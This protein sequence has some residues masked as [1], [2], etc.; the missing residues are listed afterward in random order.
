VDRRRAPTALILI[1]VLVGGCIGQANT[2]TPQP[3]QGLTPGATPGVAACRALIAADIDAAMRVRT[4]LGIDGIPAT[5]AAV[6]A[7]A[8]D[9]GSDVAA[10]GVPLTAT[11]LAALRAS[12][13]TIDASTPLT[14][15]VNVGEPRRFGG[16]WTDPAGS[17]HY[18]VGIL[19]SDPAAMTLAQC[20]GAGLDVRYVAA[21]QS[22]AV[23]QALV[24]RIAA[25]NG[26]L[27]SI[28][29]VVTSVGIAVRADVS[30][31]V[32]GVTGL[33]DS[34]RA[35]LVSRYGSSIVVEEGKPAGS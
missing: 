21:G 1:A 28:G 35:Q 25:D 31:V 33:T 9:P 3:G 11:E 18:V 32:I 20:A 10:L 22:V 30:M 6:Q 13:T 19:G 16:V 12:G 23:E 27:R 4:E 7:A 8:Q 15:L 17:P 24:A 2:T 14:T 29:I 34:I 5:A 26:D